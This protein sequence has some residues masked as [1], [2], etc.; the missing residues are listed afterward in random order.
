MIG[1]PGATLASIAADSKLSA[2]YLP[3]VWGILNDKDAVGPV[4]KLQAMWNA[5]PAAGQ[6]GRGHG[7]LGMSERVA[8]YGG[9]LNAGTPGS[10]DSSP[11]AS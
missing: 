6:T 9:A 1:K 3:L 5:L 11:A 4:A 8:L 7:L 10:R 2:K